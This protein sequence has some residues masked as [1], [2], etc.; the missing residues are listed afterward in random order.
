[1]IPNSTKSSLESVWKSLKGLPSGLRVVFVALLAVSLLALGV[2]TYAY[3][4]SQRR[5]DQFEREVGQLSDSVATLESE[6]EIKS[7]EIR[8]LQK[9]LA[10][11]ADRVDNLCDFLMDYVWC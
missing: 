6:L 9:D 8:W 7:N 1:M 5:F 4:E 11:Q 3:Q 10:E 2:G